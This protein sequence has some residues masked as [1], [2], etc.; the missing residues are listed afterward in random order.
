MNGDREQSGTAYTQYCCRR[1]VLLA[2]MVELQEKMILS[3]K[4]VWKQ[5]LAG[6][7]LEA[8]K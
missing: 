6:E 3:W 1:T 5:V 4:Q 7:F 8:E 2:E